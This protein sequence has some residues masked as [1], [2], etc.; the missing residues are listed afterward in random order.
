VHCAR[1][2]LPAR[3]IDGG[4]SLSSKSSQA[5]RCVPSRFAMNSASF[6]SRIS[7]GPDSRRQRNVIRG[8]AEYDTRG[9]A[10]TFSATSIHPTPR[11]ACAKSAKVKRCLAAGQAPNLRPL[12]TT[13]R[14]LSP[15]AARGVTSHCT[16]RIVFSA[17]VHGAKSGPPTLPISS[18]L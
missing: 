2:D 13:R 12:A 9:D 4:V 5:A 6:P 17:P 18:T 8:G 15:L 14:I 10:T 3:C 11:P 7:I 1:S 16:R